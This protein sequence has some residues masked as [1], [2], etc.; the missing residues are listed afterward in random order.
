MR[1]NSIKTLALLSVLV[2]LISGCSSNIDEEKSNIVDAAKQAFVGTPETTNTKSGEI[3]FYLPSGYQIEE[4]NEYNITLENKG[5]TI[6]LFINPN[7][8]ATSTLLL[9]LIEQNEDEYLEYAKFEEE[10]KI[11]FVALK[12]LDENTYEL[13]V[14]VG[15][16][17]ITTQTETKRLESY[18]EQLMKIANSIKQ[19]SR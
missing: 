12:E 14:G 8:A 19:Y 13:T 9:D 4:E 11:G 1:W 17:K 10:G 3:D 7:E 16:V 15:G 6:L 5:D 18:G 2:L